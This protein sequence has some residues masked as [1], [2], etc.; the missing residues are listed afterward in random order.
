MRIVCD[1]NILIRAAIHP[2]GLA[3][4]MLRLIHRGHV[5]V[6]SKP[7]LAE[8]LDV[9]R[10]EHIRA[11]HQRDETGI[12]RF[13]SRIYKW[14]V[15]VSIAPVPP[16]IVPHDPKDDAIVLTA[17]AGRADVLCSRDRHLFHP[18][19]V[20]ECARHGVRVVRDDDLLRELRSGPAAGP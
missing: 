17:I 14:S 8:A 1:T 16:A 20:A 15:C 7:L 12:R 18:G 5:S 19:V 4:E 6:T 3:A 10:R 9:L 2:D 11:L 13:V